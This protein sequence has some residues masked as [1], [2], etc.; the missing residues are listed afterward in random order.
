MGNSHRLSSQSIEI[1]KDPDQAERELVAVWGPDFR[2]IIEVESK[3]HQYLLR[4]A[5]Y[6]ITYGWTLEQIRQELF[7]V[8]D[9]RLAERKRDPGSN[10]RVTG[11]NYADIMLV[12][13][14]CA[15]GVLGNTHRDESGANDVAE[16]ELREP[17]ATP[18][19]T[20]SGRR[21]GTQKLRDN[22]AG[23]FCESPDR[24]N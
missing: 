2:Q 16:R 14:N 7:R 4:L 24:T 10:A 21:V 15:R 23:T 19:L 17:S 20:N 6:G 5:G 13:K 12:L 9:A 11:V 3:N 8:R 22:D 1:A 18:K